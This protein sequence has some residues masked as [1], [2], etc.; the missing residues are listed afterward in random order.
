MRHNR[1]VTSIE[2]RVNGVFV[3]FLASFLWLSW[4]HIIA[5]YL[6]NFNTPKNYI[7]YNIAASGLFVNYSYDFG[8]FN[9]DILI[10]CFLIYKKVYI[11]LS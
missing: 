1:K 6:Q 10:K 7:L 4:K 8:N 2:Q 3:V 9:L 5:M 11:S